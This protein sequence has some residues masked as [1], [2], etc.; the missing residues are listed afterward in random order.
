[1]YVFE[2]VK[3]L[4]GGHEGRA[5]THTHTHT[6]AFCWNTNGRE[7]HSMM[8]GCQHYL[9][10]FWLS[11]GIILCCVGWVHSPWCGQA[12]SVIFLVVRFGGLTHVHMVVSKALN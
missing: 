3:S 9:E 4:G 2:F 12:L 1:M 11:L 5:F 6:Q 8:L 7:D 10:C